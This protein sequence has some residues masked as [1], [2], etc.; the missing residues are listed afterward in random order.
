MNVA[1]CFCLSSV[2]SAKFVQLSYTIWLSTPYHI[3][4]GMHPIC[5]LFYLAQFCG[6]AAYIPIAG[7]LTPLH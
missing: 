1:A 4:F 6:F 2:G 7:L 3:A 5:F